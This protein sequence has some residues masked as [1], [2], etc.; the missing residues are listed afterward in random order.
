[1]K[2]IVVCCDKKIVGDCWDY[3]FVCGVIDCFV[4]VLGFDVFYWIDIDDECGIV[5]YVGW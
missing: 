5:V 4:I 3:G 1:M 2:L